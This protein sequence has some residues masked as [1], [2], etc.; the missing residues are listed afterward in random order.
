MR[1]AKGSGIRPATGVTALALVAFFVL[2][3]SA[4]AAPPTVAIDSTVTPGYT[5]AHVS[6]T[7]DTGGNEGYYSFERSTDEGA[8]WSGFG[9]EGFFPIG[10]G[11]IKPSID[12]GGLAPAT[13]YKVRLTIQ[14]FAPES[15]EFSTPEPSPTFTTLPVAKPAIT[16]EDPS[17]I[18]GNSAIFKGDIKPGTPA[19]DPPGFNVEWHFECTPECPEMPFEFIPADSSK[20]DYPIEVVAR[21]LKPGTDY[22]VTLVASNAGGVSSAGPKSFSEPLMLPEILVSPAHVTSTT[23]ALAGSINPGGAEVSYHFEYGPGFAQST[24]SK[25]VF[26]GSEAVPVKATITGLT[27]DTTYPW[28]LVATNSVGDA[29]SPDKSLTTE[30]S[31]APACPND[32]FRIG[33]SAALPNCRAYEMVNP[34]GPE[35][36]D[37]SRVPSVSND[38]TRLSYFTQVAPNIAKSNLTF[39]TFATQRTASGWSV[40]DSN[41]IA[42]LLPPAILFAS[43]ACYSTDYSKGVIE[44]SAVFNDF[45]QDGG[46]ADVYLLEVGTGK[47]TWESYGKPGVVYN[48]TGFVEFVGGTPDLSRVIFWDR[49]GE[50]LTEE[51]PGGNGLYAREGE[52]LKLVSV[53]PDGK[54]AD[55]GWPTG[56]N[57]GRPA[58]GQ[59]FGVSEDGSKVF[60]YPSAF[61]SGAIYRRDIDAEKTILIDGSHRT[62]NEGE[63][64]FDGTFLAATPDGETVFFSS[65]AQLT[66]A[67]S[68]GGGFYR[69]EVG[70]DHL[71]Q[72]TP[73]THSPALGLQGEGPCPKTARTSTSA[74]RG[75]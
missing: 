33:P 10:S 31:I 58:H 40:T 16:I 39:S 8:S 48:G 2:A 71:E 20:T 62:G 23:A 51:A 24:P 4:V 43:V 69:Y 55:E 12:I 7:I 28:R 42:G 72:L 60:F 70:D 44:T 37:I 13:K 74:R 32:E 75:A 47:T 49:G 6:G 64:A 15:G 3:A 30:A 63:P 11:V 66:N 17:A 56:K 54:P 21:D 29:K 14:V 68:P 41:A 35:Y 73:D 27:P 18:T 5:T 45:D 50:V 46:F 52:K 59:N 25:V 57:C 26:A 19:G 53:L 9:Y 36:G 22:Q 65:S 1:D 34:P 67:A 38:G 61:P